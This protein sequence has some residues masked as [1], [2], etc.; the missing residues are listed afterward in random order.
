[1]NLLN[2]I[3]LQ[4]NDF[5]LDKSEVYAKHI[6]NR[7]TNGLEQY[8]KILEQATQKIINQDTEKILKQL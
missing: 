4:V 1:M 8:N 5:N 6:Q 2:K 3:Y 7:L